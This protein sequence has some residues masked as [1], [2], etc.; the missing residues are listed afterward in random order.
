LTIVFKKNLALLLAFAL[1]LSSLFAFPVQASSTAVPTAVGKTECVDVTGVTAGATLKLYLTNGTLLPNTA[2][3]L[4]TGTYRFENVTPNSLGFYVTQTVD[5]IESDNTPFFGVSLRTPVASGGIKLVD[6]SDI[7][8][9]AEVKLYDNAG[10][11]VAS[12]ANVTTGTHQFTNITPGSGYYVIQSINGVVSDA[13]SSVSVSQL[14]PAAPTATGKE[15]YIDVTGVAAGATIKLYLTNGTSL[16]NTPTDLGAGT[17]RFENVTPNSLGFYVTQTVDGV[18]S[19]NTPFFSVS[20]RTPVASGGIKLV[21]VSNIY[22]GAEVKLYDNAGNLVASETNVTTGTHRFTNVTPGSGYYV[23]QTINGVVS[24]ASGSVSVSQ[25]KPAAPTATGKEEYIDVTGVAAGASIKLY[26]T[27]GTSLPN[28]PTDLGTGTYRFE[29]VTPNSLGFYVTQTVDGVESDNTPFFSVSLRTPVASGGIK[30]VDVSNIY[31][32][33]EVKLYDNAG[34]LVASETNVTTGTHRFT[35]ITPGSGYYVVQTINGVVSDASGSV[36]VSQLKP[37]APTATGKEEYIDV[38]NVTTG[39]SIKLYLT[40]GTLLPNTVTDLGAGTYRFENVTPS[41]LGFYVTQ[42]VDGVESD[43]TP[44]LGVSLRTPDVIGGVKLVDV[45][46]VYPGATLKLYNSESS[47]IASEA[48]V[49]TGTHRFTNITPGSGY[50]VVQ[51]VNGVVSTASS[52]VS[53]SPVKPDAPTAE[54]KVEFVDVTNVTTGASIKLYLTDSTLV[55]ASPS[56]KGAGIYRF[57]NVTPNSLGFYVTQTVDGVESDN[58]PFFGV[59]LR[60]PS[61][62]GGAMLVD[63]SNIY[64]G[65]TV[66]LYDSKGNLIASKTAATEATY[67]FNNITPGNGYYVMQS[68][69]GV[70]SQ[71]SGTIDVWAISSSTGGSTSTQTSTKAPANLSADIIINGKTESAGIVSTTVSGTQTVTTVSIDPSKVEQRLKSEGTNVLVTIPVNTDSDVVIGELDGQTLKNLESKQSLL[72]VRTRN[73]TYTLPAEQLNISEINRQIG[74]STELKDIKVSIVIS[75]A[76][77]KTVQLAEDS[78]K[79]GEFTIIASPVEF[80]V[81]CTYGG[82][83]IEV[84]NFNAYIERTIAIPEG[85][86]PNKITTGVVVEAD[87]STRHVPTKIKVV[88]GRYYAVINSLTNSIYSVVWHPLKFKDVNSNWAEE[89]VN[90]MGS[91]MVI[92]GVGED[93]FEP[94]R[95]IT[96]AEFASIVVRAL[97]LMPGKGSNPFNDVSSTS[98]YCDYVKTAVE[99]NI[100]TGYGN[101]SFGP[102]DKITREQAMTIIK[103]AM[104]ITGLK[105]EINS[106]EVKELL[107]TYTDA[108]TAS[109]W[110]KENIAA[111]VKSG[112]VTGRGSSVIAPG[113]NITRAETAVL[114]RKLLQ[115]S[116]LI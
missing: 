30:L 96:R 72:E 113:N 37:A 64:S 48:N 12:E 20:L 100:I 109:V 22:S 41:N 102:N 29:N 93:R 2:T 112:I 74:A 82:K 9:G 114:V 24:D 101:G 38:T 50:Y 62:S 34:N 116:G 35:N 16:P 99:Y 45:S 86:D 90:D 32:G 60:T 81:R 115:K 36:S 44:F 33:A 106:E 88:D 87:G 56:D 10:N 98:W 70:S 8:S 26:L 66:K 39:A 23:V 69:N 11:L 54:G 21:D 40:N 42:T 95:D 53:V 5:G 47:L 107:S 52:T 31:S 97:G 49:T 28:T 79:K 7:Y 25:L 65:A 103:K 85:V 13:S 73:A 89:A 76:A 19:D 68:I 91:R 67:R 27:N 94:S 110:A 63:V 111:C 61:A 17:Y 71:A 104:Q 15:E 46:N 57:E 105:V 6:V 55:S 1:L 51:S 78:A 59:S 75:K 3:D 58:T 84:S 83:T 4:G 92:S 77:Q 14:K 80:S 43:N 108:N 18:E